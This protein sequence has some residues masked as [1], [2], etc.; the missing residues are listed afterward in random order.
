MDE[1]IGEEMG[2]VFQVYVRRDREKN[3]AVVQEAID[4]GCK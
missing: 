4:G 1:Q 3:A 2:M